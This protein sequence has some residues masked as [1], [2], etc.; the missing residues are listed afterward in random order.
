MREEAKQNICDKDRIHQRLSISGLS[1]LIQVRVLMIHQHKSKREKEEPR[2]DSEYS[3]ST[4][5]DWKRQWKMIWSREWR[6][7]TMHTRRRSE[8]VL[9]MYLLWKKTIRDYSL[10]CKSRKKNQR[11]FQRMKEAASFV[12]PLRCL[13]LPK[14]HLYCIIS[15]SGS[16][17]QLLFFSFFEILTKRSFL[18][19]VFDHGKSRSSVSSFS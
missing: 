19:L 11:R 1:L 8:V 3:A 16:R 5:Q 10:L 2:G 14:M 17:E 6:V 9:L 12:L 18:S 4:E 7:S 13:S 15:A